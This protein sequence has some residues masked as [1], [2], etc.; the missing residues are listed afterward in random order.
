M[1]TT[2]SILTIILTFVFFYLVYL[3]YQKSN[4]YLELLD[5]CADLYPNHFEEMCLWH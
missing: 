4:Q 2:I 3:V 5:K 1:K